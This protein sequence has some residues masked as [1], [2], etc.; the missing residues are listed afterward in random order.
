MKKTLKHSL[1][2]LIALAMLVVMAIP[3][4]AQTVAYNG[5]D[6]ADGKITITNASKGVTYKVYKL[7][8]A[9]V[10]STNTDNVAYTL[11]GNI[12]TGLTDYFTKDN[13]P[14]ADSVIIKDAA[15]DATNS[16]KLSAAAVTAITAWAES[17]ATPIAQA[18]SAGD[19]LEFTNLPYGYYVVTTNAGT[20]IGVNSTNKEVV[21]NDKNV[22]IPT[23]L[24][25]LAS[26]DQDYNIGDTITYTITFKA[27]NYAGAD[28]NAK[29]IKTYVIK[30]TL[31]EF[32]SDVTITS[33]KVGNTE[34]TPT[35]S[36]TNKQFEIEWAT[37][38]DDNE[39]TSKY[40]NNEEVTIVYTAK[41]TDRAAIAGDGNTNKVTIAWLGTDDPEG[42]TPK[43]DWPDP[44]DPSKPT[45]VEA[46]ETIYTYAIALK[47]VNDSGSALTG[48]EFKVPFKVTKTADGQYTYAGA[49]ANESEYATVGTDN[50]G[51]VVIKGVDAGT[52]SVTET[53]A[54]DGY[55]RLT[56]AFNVVAEK[57]TETK[58]SITKY[59]DEKGD[60]TDTETTTSV[61]Y[62]NND[63][64]ASVAFVVNK[65]GSILPSTGGIGTYIVVIAGLAIVAAGV[66]LMT[67]RNKKEEE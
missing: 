7:F 65:A 60:I 59:I 17:N 23:E 62:V 41:L 37:K 34:I 66:I 25:K 51:V 35:P 27:V 52:Y 54:P 47:K 30:D 12:P 21:I 33:V 9:T 56:D 50:N 4:F 38:G 29:Q 28:E 3:A 18:T 10:D 64:S 55:N 6:K 16:T 63:L 14:Y 48:A 24:T 1:A 13:A 57:S 58:T 44:T 19:T 42:T 2:C 46:E 5:E 43:E 11:E 26:G 45:K 40:D 53:K 15:K 22:R 32:L 67:K 61:T 20:A 36:F 31:P 49:A 39:W 8:D